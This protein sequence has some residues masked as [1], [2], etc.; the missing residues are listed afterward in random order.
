MKLSWL[1]HSRDE[2]RTSI[3]QFA[4]QVFTVN[5]S[6]QEIIAWILKKFLSIILRNL[7]VCL[8]PYLNSLWETTLSHLI[9]RLTVVCD[10]KLCIWSRAHVPPLPPWRS[11][12]KKASVCN[13]TEWCRWCSSHEHRRTHWRQPC[14]P[15][16][17][18]VFMP[19][20]ACLQC[21]EIQI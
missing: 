19:G 15:V 5:C 7:F 3:Y 16:T 1:K 2:A 20:I 17:A 10:T 18:C 4:F 21:Y 6:Q 8:F 9:G 14:I 12:M 11:M 13:S